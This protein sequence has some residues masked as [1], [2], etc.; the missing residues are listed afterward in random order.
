MPR[1]P[2]V[3]IDNGYYHVVTR[4]IDKRRLFQDQQDYRCFKE[5][6]KEYLDEFQVNILHYCLMP[7]HIHLLI[8]AI[9][10]DD[11]PKYMQG[12][13]QVYASQFRKKYQS[14]GFIYQNRYKSNLIDKD[15]YLLECARYI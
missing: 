12:V 8:W 1:R 10:A 2:R 15:S 11:L 5:L 6:M 7:N 9:N 14:V 4:G 3:L 13:L